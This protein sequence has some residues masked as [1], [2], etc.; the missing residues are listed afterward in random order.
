L[1]VLAASYAQLGMIEKTRDASRE[2][3]TAEQGDKTIAAVVAPFR[4]AAD[5]EIYAEGLGKAGM[6]EG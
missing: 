5:R 6:P 2:L 4:R 3:L 1:R